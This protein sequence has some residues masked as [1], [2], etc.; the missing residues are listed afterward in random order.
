M[1]NTLSDNIKKLGRVTE[2][3]ERL[4]NPRIYYLGSY[5]PQ[6]LCDNANKKLLK[7]TMRSM[8]RLTAVIQKQ[9]TEEMQKMFPHFGLSLK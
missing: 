5:R 3:I 7:Q 2:A 4:S 6:R 1:R 9:T 8:R